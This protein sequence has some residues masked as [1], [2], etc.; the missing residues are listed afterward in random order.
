[1]YC[2]MHCMQ[3]N[4]RAVL[5]GERSFGKGVIQSLQ[6]LSQGAGLAVTTARY[7]TPL[8]RNINK[9]TSI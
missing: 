7:E 2:I 3:E 9:V 8:H 6:S 1:M 5:V 4:G